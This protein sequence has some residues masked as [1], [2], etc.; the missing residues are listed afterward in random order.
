MTII[1]I[2][3]FDGTNYRPRMTYIEHCFLHDVAWRRCIIIEI[4]KIVLFP[5]AHE[6]RHWPLPSFCIILLQLVHHNNYYYI[7][8]RLCKY[9]IVVQKLYRRIDP[10]SNGTRAHSCFAGTLCNGY[11]LIALYYFRRPSVL[12]GLH[13]SVYR[14]RRR[15]RRHRRRRRRRGLR[16]TRFYGRY[17][18]RCSCKRPFVAET[19]AKHRCRTVALYGLVLFNNI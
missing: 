17:G 16:E 15:H 19:F 1:S 6:P 12:A 8:M 11:R 5:F 4:S 3:Y 2:L 14:R 13:L 10:N 18:E 7:P 9:F